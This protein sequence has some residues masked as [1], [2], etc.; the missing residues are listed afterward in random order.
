[1]KEKLNWFKSLINKNLEFEL[2]FIIL[3][4]ALKFNIKASTNN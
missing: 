1:M 4:F 2:K 3:N